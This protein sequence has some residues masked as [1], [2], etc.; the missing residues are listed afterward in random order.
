MIT[1]VKKDSATKRARAFNCGK[2]VHGSNQQLGSISG[3]PLTNNFISEISLST[4]SMLKR[5]LGVSGNQLARLRQKTIQLNDKVY[6]FVLQHRF[7]MHVG[8]QERD[9]IALD[10]IVNERSSKPSIQP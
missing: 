3:P 5:E 1:G 9:I 6:Q 8:N 4:S 10:E 2:L 7:D